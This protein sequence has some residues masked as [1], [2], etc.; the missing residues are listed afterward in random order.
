MYLVYFVILFKKIETYIFAQE[1]NHVKAGARYQF[2]MHNY[3][4][5]TNLAK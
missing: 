3:Y 2:S 1:S 5:E 4:S